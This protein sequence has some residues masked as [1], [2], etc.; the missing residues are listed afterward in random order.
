MCFLSTGNSDN[1]EIA[2]AINIIQNCKLI[3]TRLDNSIDSVNLKAILSM[4]KYFSKPVAF[5]NHCEHHEV[6]FAASMFNPSDYFF[7]VKDESDIIP[8][9]DNLHA[10]EI[11]NVNYFSKKIKLLKGAIGNGI[12]EKTIN[13]IKGQI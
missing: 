8:P 9:P 6:L 7:Y 4:K 12:K 1:R 5:G 13:S 3:H 2:K 10:I 11:K